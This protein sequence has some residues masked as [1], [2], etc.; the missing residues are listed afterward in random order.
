M[1]IDT[2]SSEPPEMF[3]AELGVDEVESLVPPVEAVFE[4]R[5]KD[6][7]LLVGAVEESANVTM[8]AEIAS[9]ELYG[10]INGHTSPHMHSRHTKGDLISGS[11]GI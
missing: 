11:I 2:C 1:H 10:M 3:F 9:G 7:I 4:E 5:T 8:P 6:S